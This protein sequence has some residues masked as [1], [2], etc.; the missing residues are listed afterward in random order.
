MQ[1]SENQSNLSIFQAIG[2]SSDMFSNPN[3][4]NGYPEGGKPS[5]SISRIRHASYYANFNY[6]YQLRYLL[7]FNLRSDGSSVYGVD[8]PFSTTWSLGLGW[9]IH[10][11]S[12][13]RQNNILNYMKLRY[14]VG[15]PGNANLNAKW[16]T[17]YILIIPAIRICSVCQ[18]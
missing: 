11:E 3:F 2:Y 14:S 5:S 6:G 8:N 15:N 1:I 7:D 9:N 18:L 12:F 17:A 16:L 13:F 4:S 10:N